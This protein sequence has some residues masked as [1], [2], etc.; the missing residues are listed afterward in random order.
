[1][2]TIET[3]A[4]VLRVVDFGES[5]RIAHLLTPVTSR[6][7][8]IAKGA[9]RS[10][11]RFPGTLDLFHLLDVRIERRRP[12]SM[13]RLEQARLLDAWTPLRRHPARFAL[14]CYLAELVDR[15]ATEGTG[16]REARDLFAAVLGA[17]R[18]AA[19]REPTPRMRALLELR[20]LAAIGLEPELRRC[21]R[22]GRDADA[23]GAAAGESAKVAFHVA[24]GG[25][26]CVGCTAVGDPCMTLHRGTLRALEQGLRLPFDRIDRLALGAEPTAEARALLARFLRFHVGFELRSERF[27][28]SLLASG[29]VR[30]LA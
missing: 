2:A 23:S 22:C 27:L 6:L 13:A 10:K 16:G 18:A 30:A 12:T 3:Q 25:P 8:V 15:L 1:M 9:K 19:S 20:V 29:T 7:T 14:A 5:D 28:D 21:V 24:E 26:L 17:L 11:R 4:L